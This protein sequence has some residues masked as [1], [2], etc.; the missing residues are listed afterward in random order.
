MGAALQQTIPS[1][2]DPA[3]SFHAP[4]PDL[5]TEFFERALY[6]QNSVSAHSSRSLPPKQAQRCIIRLHPTKVT[7][8]P[9][10]QRPCALL[11]TQSQFLCKSS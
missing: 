7:L 10:P 1:D 6:A 4:P 5:K 8:R 3:G 9:T 2:E 11:R